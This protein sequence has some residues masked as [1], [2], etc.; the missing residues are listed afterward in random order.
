[1]EVRLPQ[2]L[3]T[4]KRPNLPCGTI[5]SMKKL[6]IGNWKMNPKSAREAMLIG[7]AVKKGAARYKK[8]ETAIC[9]PYPFLALIKGVTLGSQDVS[10]ESA[11]ARTGQVSAPM[12]KS[13][14]VK[15]IIVGHSERRAMG[16]TYDTVNKKIK[17]LIKSKITPV[18]CV[19]EKERDPH[20]RYLHVVKDELAAAL[21]GIPKNK[22]SGI[23][24]AY[25]PIWAVGAKAKGVLDAEEALHMNIFIRK[26]VADIAGAESAK[27]LRVLYGG[28][29]EARNSLGFLTVGKMDGLLVGRES[30]DPKTFLE[31]VKT[32]N[33]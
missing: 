33:N 21:R 12:L 14:G 8:V 24:V 32:A 30:L 18:L 6:I 5:T 28:S 9:P 29:V 23:V 1:M 22:I 11:G 13:I 2:N 31:I 4:D 17:E 19:G 7:R 10:H 20:S 25:E 15:Y 27:K 26:V 16:E 3:L